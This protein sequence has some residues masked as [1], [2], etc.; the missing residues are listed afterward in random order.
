MLG[1]A[2]KVQFK[3]VVLGEDNRVHDKENVVVA[4][5]FCF[6]LNRYSKAN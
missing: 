3:F 1:C 4:G 5:S 2:G 6:E